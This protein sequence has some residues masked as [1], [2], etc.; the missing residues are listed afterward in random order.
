MLNALP[1]IEPVK[2]WAPMVSEAPVMFVVRRPF[3]RSKD[4]A[5]ELE[6]V[7]DEKNWPAVLKDPAVIPLVAVNDFEIFNEPENVDE[8]VPLKA[9]L[10]VLMVKAVPVIAPE[11]M[12]PDVVKEP[13]VMPLVAVR[14]FEMLSDPANEL[15]PTPVEKS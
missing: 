11:L 5:N 14:L 4:P 9:A 15:E 7:P 3:E 6:P 1:V 12:A 2:V 8:P 13:A 10:P